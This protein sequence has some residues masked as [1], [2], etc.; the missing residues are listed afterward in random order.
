MNS[1]IFYRN[2]YHCYYN[3]VVA[4]SSCCVCI[5]VVPGTVVITDKAFNAF[6]KESH[7]VVR[8]KHYRHGYDRGYKLFFNQNLGKSTI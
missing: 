6:L 3:V 5:G 2:H 7:D 4:F 1:L 8:E